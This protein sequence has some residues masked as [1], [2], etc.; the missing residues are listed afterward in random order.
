M[1]IIVMMFPFKLGIHWL[2][3]KLTNNITN[4]NVSNR[5]F[6]FVYRIV[7][8]LFPGYNSYGSKHLLRIH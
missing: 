5:L 1:G 2:L 4:I 7:G 3:T 6:V 8:Y